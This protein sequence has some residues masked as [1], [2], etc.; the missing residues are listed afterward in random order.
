[1]EGPGGEAAEETILAVDIFERSGMDATAGCGAGTPLDH[2]VEL[3]EG[4][5][6]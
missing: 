4:P 1:M 5:C 2:P 3:P 6:G